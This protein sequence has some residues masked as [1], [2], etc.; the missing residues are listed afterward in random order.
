MRPLFSTLLAFSISTVA[1]A[2][3]AN[4]AAQTQRVSN[5]GSLTSG[6]NLSQSSSQNPL[7]NHFPSFSTP[8]FS[9]IATFLNNHSNV[10]FTAD[11]LA[12]LFTSLSTL[13]KNHQFDPQSL[14]DPQSLIDQLHLDPALLAKVETFLQNFKNGQFNLGNFIHGSDDQSNNG[15]GDA[16]GDNE[17]NDDHG[18]PQNDNDSTVTTAVPEPNM[19]VAFLTGAGLLSL[20]FLRPRRRR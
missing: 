6:F 18:Q 17:L 8:D 2:G 5:F 12:T 16:N 20:T 14:R 7:N 10:Q 13:L 11:D 19:F 3:S 4:H 1:F 15:N 9:L